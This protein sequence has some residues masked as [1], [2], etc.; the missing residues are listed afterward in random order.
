MSIISNLADIKIRINNI[1]DYNKLFEDDYLKNLKNIINSG[2]YILGDIVETF[3][4]K[5]A[6]SIGVNYAVGVNSGT[7]ALELAFHLLELSYED[8]VIMQANAYI[9]CAF[10]A[11]KSNGTLRIIDCDENGVFDINECKKAINSKTKAILVVHLYGDCCNME[12]LSQ[13]C[14]E[15][16]LI[17]IE[18]CAQA[19]GTK[20]NG[21]MIGSYGDMSCFSFYPSKNLGALGDGGA[22]CTN[23]IFYMEK[24]KLLRNLGAK[25]KYEHDIIA[26]NSRL[27]SLQASFLL[28]KFDDM[29]RCILHKNE[30]VKSYNIPHWARHIQNPDEKVYHSYHLYVIQ[31]GEKV[32]RDKFMEYMNNAGIETLVHYKIPFYK[33]KAFKHLNNLT[34]HNS[35][36][37]SDTIVSLP[38]YNIMELKDVEYINNNF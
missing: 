30:L 19:Q 29:N 5:L 15:N 27:D 9:A 13:L 12:K 22:I 4:S 23:N 35:E 38:I 1:K 34:F 3:E 36:K 14:N 11:I 7:S 37:L 2:Q 18:D 24:L 17:L 20:Y 32:S 10:G 33:S 25:I 8:E 21:K 26:T 31:L 16:K 6:K 28:S